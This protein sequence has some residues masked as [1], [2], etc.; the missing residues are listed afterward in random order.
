M[1]TALTRL[2][3]LVLT[4]VLADLAY[5]HGPRHQVLKEEYKVSRSAGGYRNAPPPESL[6]G[7]FTLSAPDGTPVTEKSYPSQWKLV[8][9]GYP[10]CREACPTALERLT[11]ALET[12]GP[13]A[14]MVR[15]LFVDVSMERPDPK[16]VAQFVGNFHPSIVGLTGSRAQIFEMIR[17]FQVRREYGRRSGPTE[18]GPRIDHTTLFYLID[19]AGKTRDYFHHELTPAEM[20]TAL[21]RHIPG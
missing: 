1:T 8:F 7:A 12:L 18:T 21:R 20:V 6:G 19:P 9:F 2:V 11:Q 13:T 3:S 15:P 4:V 14:E 17:L 10:S 16:G 5:A